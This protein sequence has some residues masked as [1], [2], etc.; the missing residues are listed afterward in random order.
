MVR[1]VHDIWYLI[2]VMYYNYINILN[3][4]IGEPA[5]YCIHSIYQ[6]D[7]KTVGKGSVSTDYVRIDVGIWCN[8]YRHATA[9]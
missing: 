2:M 7:G 9:M 4:Y 1:K 5:P 8:V 6:H 3:M